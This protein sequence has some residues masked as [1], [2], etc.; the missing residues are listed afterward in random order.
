MLHDSKR[1]F[2]VLIFLIAE[3]LLFGFIKV[4]T[5][6]EKQEEAKPLASAASETDMA[7]AN[8]HYSVRSAGSAIGDGRIFTRNV[9]SFSAGTLSIFFIIK[10]FFLK[11]E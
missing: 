5:E 9:P 2:M 1:Y 3:I 4:S 7:A 8:K 11:R 10:H 6:I